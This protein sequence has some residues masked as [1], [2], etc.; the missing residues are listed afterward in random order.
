M[1]TT[2]T[3]LLGSS[4]NFC[5]PAKTLEL[6]AEAGRRQPRTP[7]MAADLADHDRILQE[8]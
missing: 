8:W 7:V 5:G 4:S 2:A 1:H 3:S 6:K